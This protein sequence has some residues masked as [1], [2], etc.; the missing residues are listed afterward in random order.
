VT[1]HIVDTGSLRIIDL[2]PGHMAPIRA[3]A[4]KDPQ[5]DF[6]DAAIVRISEMFPLAKVITTDSGHFTIYRR[7]GNK[8]LPLIHP[9]ASGH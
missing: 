7:F 3:L 9:A 6:C 5:M 2:L 8:P 1:D 4:A